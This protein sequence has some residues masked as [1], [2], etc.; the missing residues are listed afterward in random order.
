MQVK[1]LQMKRVLRTALLVLLL[2]AA[3]M[4]NG[5]A[6]DFSAVCSTGQTLYYN[7]T[8]TTNHYVRITHPNN[9]TSNP[10]GNYTKPEGVLVLPDNVMNEGIA[11]TVTS[12]D[13]YAF[14]SCYDIEELTIGSEIAAVYDYS[15]WNC[16]SLTMVHFNAINCTRM[17]TYVA[18]STVWNSY[19]R[20]VFN[21]GNSTNGV[22][23]ITTLTIG[24]NVTSIPDYA[25]RNCNGLAT[26]NWNAVNVTNY[27]GSAFLECTNLTTVVF[28]NQVQTIPANAF[29]SFNSIIDLTIGN[30]VTSVG[31]NAF[32]GCSGLIGSLTIPNSVTSIG[33]EAFSG[34]GG[35][36]SLTIGNSV[37]SIGNSA[38]S[39]C[40]ELSI[41]NWNAVDVIN[42]P[43]S[44]SNHPYGNCNNLTT[45]VFGDQVEMIPDYA[46]KDCSSIT[47]LTIGDSVTSIGMSAFYGCSG[48]DS[49]MI[50]T[51]VTSIGRYAFKNCSGLTIV[52]WNAVNATCYPSYYANYQPFQDCTNLTTIMFGDQ[53]QTIP[54]YTF[55][56]CSS[57]SG[58]L[59]IPN[60]VTSIGDYA[61]YGCSGLST[62]NWNAENVTSYPG[63]NSAFSNCPDLTTVIF[64][65]QVQTIPTHAFYNCSSLTGS[66]TIPS[67]VTSIGDNA[68]RGCSGL[69]TLHWNAVNVTSYP[70]YNSNPFIN[71]TNLTTVVFG[72]QV[73]TIPTHAF[74]NCSSL[75]GS[76][77]IPSSVT[78][79]GNRVFY[80]CIGLT[81]SLTVPNSVT[82]IGNEAFYNC[83]GLTGTLT[84][85]NSVTTIGDYAF[86]GCSGLT[87][88]L[89]IPT[90]VT[91]IGVRAFRN[92]S[93]LTGTL[94]IGNS[95]ITIGDYAFDGCIGLTGSLAIP[96]SVT[97][98]GG[99]VF[100]GCSGLT[101][102]TIGNSLTTIS[103]S[104]F[105][106]CTGLTNIIIPNTVTT[107]G[108]NAFTDCTGITSV[109]VLNGELGSYAFSGCTNLQEVTI[110][111]TSINEYAFNGC[112]S[113]Q[114]LNFDEGTLYIGQYA[115]NGC[116]GLTSVSIPNSVE[117]I[118]IRAFYGN[119]NL[120]EV[121]IGEGVAAICEKAFWNCPSL[122]TVHFNAVNCSTMQTYNASNNYSVFSKSSD[123]PESAINT[124]TIGEN[125]T[126]IPD[127]A[128][129]TARR[130]TSIN[131]PNS[132]TYIGKCAFRACD[133]VQTIVIGNGVT[134][135]GE[136]AF[137]YCHNAQE[138]TIGENVDTIGAKAFW[139]CPA[140]T[141]V[142]FNAVN[143]TSMQTSYNND[144]YSV[145]SSDISG[146]S[147]AIT[148]VIL[149]SNVTR[150]PDYAF[151][152]ISNLQRLI[153]PASVTYIGDY[154]FYNCN[155]L[156]LLRVLGTSLTS[157][158]E[159]A[160]YGCSNMVY[161]MNLPDL[162]HI[163]QYA[164]YNCSA[165]TG[166]LTIPSSI[167][168]I[169]QY[170]FY[171]CSG[172]TGSLT[173]SDDVV[174]IGEGAFQNCSGLNGI[175]TMP[176][177]VTSI[178]ANAFYNCSSLTGD[179]NIPNNVT[180]IGE[181]A[182][183][184]CSGFTGEI[185]VPRLA[186][187]IGANTFYNCNGLSGNLIIPKS[188]TSV[189][190]GAFYNCNNLT[191]IISECLNPPVAQP[192]SFENMTYTV[193]V[194][195]P[196]GMGPNYQSATGWNVFT[197]YVDQFQ[198]EQY[199]TDYWSDEYNWYTFE[200]P[201]SSDVVCINSD[202]QLNVDAS[203]LYLY[204]RSPNNTLTIKSG[205]TLYVAYG[206]GL[207]NPSQIII[208]EGGHIIVGNSI[209]Y[210]ISV[211]A[212]PIEGGT[213]T[214]AGTYNYCT[215]ATL[216][217][218]A[219]EGYS[220]VNWTKNGIEVS[221]ETNYTFLVI[222]SGQYVANFELNTYEINISANPEDSGAV[223]GA[224]IYA[225]GTI[226]TLNATANEGFDFINWTENGEEV[227]VDSTYSFTVTGARTLVANFNED[228][229]GESI[230]FADA[231]V[232]ALCVA[233]WDTNGDGEL[234]YA[235]AAAVTDLG[236]VFRYNSSITSFDEL[237]Y[238]TGLTAIGYMAFSGC[239]NLASVSIPNSVT[240]I[241]DHAF[242]NCSNFT[243]LTIPNSVT[244]IWGYAFYGC[245]GLTSLTIPNSVTSI[246]SHAFFSCG[247]L[248]G[249][250]IIPNS[251]TSI[252]IYAF[253]GCSGLTGLT[254]PNSVTSISNFA[255]Y[256]CSSLTGTLVI[257]S[258]VTSIG[259]SAFSGCIGINAIR[260]QC[261]VP[262]TINQYS[263]YDVDKSIPVFV[264]CGTQE[265]YL[266]ANYWSEF[267]DINE[268]PYDLIVT[269]ND[270][271]GGEAFVT[272]YADCEDSQCVIHAEPNIGYSFTGWYV[273]DELLT[274]SALYDFV[275]VNDIT[276]EA[277]FSRNANHNIANGTTN[278]WSNPNTW[279]SGV[280]PS[281]TSTVAIYKDIIVDVDAEVEQ[282]GIYN[283]KSITISPEITLT[284]TDELESNSTS[285]III[286]D[287]GQ[288][289][290][291]N[292]EAM[293]TV[294][295]SI[296]PYT[297]D[298]D[299]WNLISFPLKGNEA[300]S[301]IENM[302]NNE[303]DLY[304]Y[305]EP[306]QYWINQKE[307]SN[308][309][310]A[311]E[312]GKGYLYANSGSENLIYSFEDNNIDG[313][314]TIDADGDGYN[315]ELSTISA[316]I[317]T[318]CVQSSS[319]INGIGVLT[320]DN[321]IV[322]PQLTFNSLSSVSFW[323]CARD[324]NYAAD[325]FGVAVS[326]MSNTDPADF[327]II[328]E[329]T[330]TA[331]SEKALGYWYQFTVDLSQLAGQM[332]Y[333]ALRHFNC[334]DQYYI[335]V[336]EITLFEVDP[337][338]PQS[339]I[340]SFA[341]ELESGSST[342]TV[343]L[344]YTETV[345]NLKGFN[346]VGNP[347]VH[348]VTTYAS[349]N[350]A[351][352][353]F[354]LNE[355]KD[356]LI[357]S[358]VSETQPL[359]PAEGF[360]VKATAEESSITFNPGRS[361]D[362][363]E[364]KGFVNLEL[365]ENGKLIDR[366]I[367][368]REGEP[369]E[370]LSLNGHSTKVYAQNGQN[371]LAIVSCEN[372]EQAVCFKAAKNGSYTINVSID[373]LKVD[374]LHLIDNLTGN[375]IDLLVTPSYTF[376]AKTNDYASRFRLVFVCGDANDDNEGEN[377]TPFAYICNGDIIITADA[378]DASLQVIDA[379]GHVLVCR[380]ALSASVISTAGMTP[381]VYMLRLIQGND[382]K[383]QKM[384][385]K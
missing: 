350:V 148:T 172:L 314:T 295:K 255:F 288:L 54:A 64:G 152:N 149:G 194:H 239:N 357:V 281:S 115:F 324:A 10:W 79:I 217:A 296:E 304:A 220:F 279:D 345:G 176:N 98:I 32:S 251:V 62:V 270:P 237:Q 222:E 354:R 50:P 81:G 101:G 183:Y 230:V 61:F 53:V 184:N 368:K 212:N 92:C 178:G 164:F 311:L 374:Y 21:T 74:Y 68:F 346:L 328:E 129:R 175:L 195:V 169:G 177:N 45:V 114:S 213:V 241:G 196:Y 136:E 277:R 34:C 23:A 165:M 30:S 226:A 56:N 302:L 94:T 299:G 308:C 275:M 372:D 383:V 291:S 156:V 112:T 265:A 306:T 52:N 204:F 139:C 128:F 209:G 144:F 284:V 146:E 166:N 160:F 337:V 182:F 145:F 364:R 289:Y 137:W 256:N 86:D 232:K 250:L 309:F 154:A 75:T 41:L 208:E 8:D 6:Y 347:Y 206:I 259:N 46:F 260:L 163:G 240:E 60:S 207:D 83:I 227:S 118:G 22:S 84:I 104:A 370:K 283:G 332:G 235:E 365:R 107:I 253:W 66:L 276:I 138:V 55:Y 271:Y 228:T 221:T 248:T 336:D 109:V 24:E 320:P 125:V 229:S 199:Y 287:G 189:G 254:I 375:D 100:F 280:V 37:T 96:N 224:G 325:H 87:G 341:G 218:T 120:Q 49:L 57:L 80:N 159:Y 2:G 269:Q 360:F 5:Y 233:N 215:T 91:S 76:L 191:S 180:T 378:Y 88:S 124:L 331:K 170:T 99:G 72:N 333:V 318:G 162:N 371:E 106:G 122:T 278:I 236:T 294:K 249:T 186:T 313:W 344:S 135:I 197:N 245:V 123:N 19:Y 70:G 261:P 243:G 47:N 266:A 174:S 198:F 33:D 187:A 18:G 90:S 262:P 25:F 366:L 133:D 42:Y 16:P 4:K 258:S 223:S 210:T 71:C 69:T 155:E 214:G 349:T 238:F 127:Y 97:S 340:L 173:I 339:V 244:T 142:R 119:S 35:L 59:T 150:I 201:T 181:G 351:D 40:N 380:D 67:S 13:S 348:N 26:V 179:L 369:L 171:N 77:T 319:Y 242:Y 7:I 161:T 51:S 355:V 298:A 379:M 29:S 367:V 126:R 167:D 330:M 326:T 117:S 140:L 192:S 102:L 158:G 264:A 343:P 353:C 17:Y 310:T 43:S 108:T 141:T 15:F 307:E 301:S 342:I 28:G 327:T 111:A 385:I 257:P 358:E 95:V 202:C 14:Y 303:Y 362:E 317:G 268:S 273:D 361:K 356:N 292:D 105:Q 334:S 300:V 3:G 286:E 272:Q 315:W 293:A 384:V 190:E 322:S 203:I 110:G 382:V 305:D 48:L 359:H 216:T 31:N 247:G 263:F 65:N 338:E 290:H 89:A 168:T 130:L 121:T 78:S 85:G 132:V 274:G 93:G 297:T 188:I 312:A 316:Y 113:L 147:P 363:T 20:S 12:I 377:E 103:Y 335:M 134:R 38:F 329:W 285:S 234:S 267:T 211:S 381:G 9:S 63:N 252:G 185:H 323:A 151:K 27:A 321:Y 1:D 246:G 39:G 193:P 231:N 373:S 376:E 131:I 205:K 73:Q 153:I 219:N 200:L 282:I 157:I 58:A 143:C 82:I 44:T 352:G 11:Y 36:T 225:H 116:I